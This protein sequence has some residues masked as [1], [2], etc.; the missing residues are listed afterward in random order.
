MPISMRQVRAFRVTG[1]DIFCRSLAEGRSRFMESRD[2]E[3][4]SGSGSS[5]RAGIKHY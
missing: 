3:T 1:F 5:Q 2:G 4:T